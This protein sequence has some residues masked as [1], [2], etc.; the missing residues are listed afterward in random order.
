M[1]YDETDQTK[2]ARTTFPSSLRF[3]AWTAGF[4]FGIEEEIGP[5]SPEKVHDVANEFLRGFTERWLGSGSS[6]SAC[7]SQCLNTEELNAASVR[8]DTGG[9]GSAAGVGSAKGSG[10]C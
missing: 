7:R 5:P 1:N 4:Y 10:D 8:S 9:S 6:S 3:R 2:W